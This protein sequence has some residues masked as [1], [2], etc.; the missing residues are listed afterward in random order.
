MK[1]IRTEFK[2]GVPLK[3]LYEKGQ[4]FHDHVYE[5]GLKEV[6]DLIEK[7]DESRDHLYVFASEGCHIDFYFD[8]ERNLWVDIQDSDL[9]AISK[10]PNL[11]A[12]RAIVEIANEGRAFGKRVP[13]TSQEW[14]AYG[15]ISTS[16]DEPLS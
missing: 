15:S 13:N 16:E 7:L 2:K 10:L 12:A 4:D 1:V 3:K 8:D 6:V 9:W 11:D 14:G 5:A